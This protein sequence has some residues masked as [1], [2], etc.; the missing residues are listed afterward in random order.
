MTDAPS[1]A[2]IV[3]TMNRAKRLDA[4]LASVF[5]QTYRPLEAIVVDGGSTDRT[6]SVVDRYREEYG[7]DRITYFRN[8]EPQGLPAARN[9]AATVTDATFLA[10]LDDDD[11]WHP[12]KIERQVAQFTASDHEIGLSYTGRVSRT[13]SGEHVH[14][15]RP[16]VDGDA[17]R[18]LLVHNVIGSPSRAMVTAEAFEAVG[19]F[20]EELRHQEDWDFYLRIARAYEI[21]CVPAPLVTR[22]THRGGMS[23][24][25]TTQ[26][27]Y[28]ERLLNRYHSELRTHGVYNAAWA[29]LHR[30][31][32]IAYAQ[33]GNTAM[34]RRELR[35]ALRYEPTLRG[36]VSYVFALF[37]PP[38]FR[39]ATRIKRA[40]ERARNRPTY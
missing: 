14:T 40:L 13:E 11:R 5:A 16:S 3:P 20:D 15:A 19:G 23:T 12:E 30:E 39:L 17:Y 35:E 32:G 2:A 10:F 4:A 21:G 29:A 33:S 24:D 6:P 18:D 36:V 25:V 37:G 9:Q 27:A 1:V 28:G 31:A 22:L 38:G 8:D 34:G 26:K 7:D